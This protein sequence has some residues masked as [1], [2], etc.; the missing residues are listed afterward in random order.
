MTI[1]EKRNTRSLNKIHEYICREMGCRIDDLYSNG[2]TFIE[3]ESKTGYVKILSVRNADIVAA[4]SDLYASVRNS[5]AGK[6]R[7][8]LYES[9][10][11]YGQT[12]HYI[13]HRFQLTTVPFNNP[14]EYQMLEGDEI[15]TLRGLE[16]FENALGFDALGRTPTCSV[17]YAKY[18]DEIV[19]LA[20]ASY[21]DDQLR[22]IGV[23]VKPEYRGRGLASLLVR[24]LTAELLNRR[25]VPFYS[26]SSTNLGSQ[27]VAIRSGYMPYWTD[28]YGTRKS[29]PIS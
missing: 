20:G 7:D 16:G 23:D 14:Y 25:L 28:S 29:A 11:V 15:E 27:A 17:M 8:E 9:Q 5:L 26:A 21:V 1:D 24:N 13:P 22:E 12:I 18:Q 6:S 4:S 2:L 19:A 3:D 10:W